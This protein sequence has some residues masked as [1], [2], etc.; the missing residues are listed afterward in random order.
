MEFRNF[1]QFVNKYFKLNTWLLLTTACIA[2]SESISAQTLSKIK[3]DVAQAEESLLWK[4]EGNGLLK[5]SYLFGTIHLIPEDK[6]FFTK[7]MENAFAQSDQVI[8]EIDMNVM[9]DMSQM[10]GLLSKM[11][12]PDSITLQDLIS[13]EDYQLLQEKAKENGLPLFY[14]E[15]IKPLF[16]QSIIGDVNSKKNQMISYEINLAEKA[17]N[18]GKSIGGL[19][20]IDDQM[21]AI[22]VVPLKEQAAMLIESFKSTN[23][24]NFD[25]IVQLYVQQ[26]LQ[27][28]QVMLESSFTKTDNNYLDSFLKNRN[29]KWIDNMKKLMSEKPTFFAVGAGHLAGKNGVINLL[30]DN[31]YKV[32]AIK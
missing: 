17:S 13:P 32:T 25:T 5:P 3:V 8:F 2:F 29:V 22:D 19:E 9:N 30:K 7:E 12:M 23:S 26:K 15:N 1:Y 10:A 6:Y 20:T 16:L 14:F 4:I 21:A 27:E 11:R 31:G 18:T 24:Q 28:L